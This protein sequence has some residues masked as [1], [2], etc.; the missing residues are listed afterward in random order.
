MSWRLLLQTLAVIVLAVETTGCG[1]FIAHRLQQSPNTYPTWFAPAAPV[2]LAFD[3]KFLTNFP[4]RYAEVGPPPA[5][6]CYRVIDPADYHVS[7]TSSNWLEDGKPQYQFDFQADVPGPT[8]AWTTAPRGTV[9]LLHGYGL[10]QFSM[11]PWAL[12]LAEAGWRCVLVDLRGH[13]KSGGRQIYFGLRE[14]NDLSQLLDELDGEAPRTGPVAV[15]GESYGAAL[16]LRWKTVEPR[17]QS[18][19]AIAPYGSLSNAVLNIARDYADWVPK[20]LIRSG[21]RKLP[22]CLGVA[23]DELNTTTVLARKPVTALFIAGARDTVAPP[24]EVA[25]LERLAAPGSRLIVVP[26]ATHEALT[27]YFDDLTD[28]ILQWLAGPGK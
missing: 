22:G 19:V 25:A 7:V 4:K 9:F 27:Y 28:P 11:A 2:T 8:N 14:T 23:P 1:T 13:G 21:M 3:P 15:V 26:Q 5:R 20:G 18:V 16:A 12:R 17:V 10:A 24:D 6:L